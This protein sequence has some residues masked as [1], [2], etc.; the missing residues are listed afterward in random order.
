MRKER[1]KKVKRRALYSESI[2]ET[3]IRRDDNTNRLVR[4]RISELF[5]IILSE[6]K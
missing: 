4:T 6:D 2:D 3:K 1:I 5:Q